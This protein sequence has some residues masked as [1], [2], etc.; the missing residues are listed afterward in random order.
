MIY[1]MNRSLQ[2]DYYKNDT[3]MEVCHDVSLMQYFFKKG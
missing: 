3:S 1:E 2:G